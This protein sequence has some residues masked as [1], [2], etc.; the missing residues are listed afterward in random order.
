MFLTTDYTDLH[1]PIE[2]GDRQ[3][4][5]LLCKMLDCLNYD[6]KLHKGNTEGRG[7]K[8]VRVSPDSYR[9]GVKPSLLVGTTVR[10]Y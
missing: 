3:I 1:P 4:F 10:N 5:I 6:A 9:V 2:I 8:P 7:N